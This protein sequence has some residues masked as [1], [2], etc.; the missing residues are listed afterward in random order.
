VRSPA[1]RRSQSKGE[2]RRE[3]ERRK[4]TGV[5]DVHG[6]RR[7]GSRDDERRRHLGVQGGEARVGH[8][9]DEISAVVSA[10]TAHFQFILTGRNRHFRVSRPRTQPH[11][12]GA[13][14]IASLA[15]RRSTAIR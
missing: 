9:V 7:A 1:R 10:R 3:K 4:L 11:P 15:Q 2:T 8:V 14:I 6:R 13:S 5:L 12:A